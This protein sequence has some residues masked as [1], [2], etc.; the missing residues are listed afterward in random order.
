MGI[1]KT[2]MKTIKLEW[3]RRN[4]NLWELF[5][6][7]Q[8]KGGL[9]CIRSDKGGSVFSAVIGG[10][11]LKPMPEIGEATDGE[12]NFL[13]LYRAKRAMWIEVVEKQQGVSINLKDFNHVADASYVKNATVSKH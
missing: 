12:G 5:V 2:R 8:R 4:G 11:H 9:K 13:S 3:K 7:G 6:N 10:S 1:R